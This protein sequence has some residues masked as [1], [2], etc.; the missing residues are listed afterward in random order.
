MCGLILGHSR[1]NPT[2]PG[3]IRPSTMM[4]AISV[5]FATAALYAQDARPAFEAAT[6]KI[7]T[8]GS[9]H[10]R[11]DGSRTQLI[12]SNQTLKRLIER[13]YN[14]KPFQVTGPAWMEDVRLDI[15]AKYPSDLKLDQ[16]MPMLRTLLEDRLKLAV[17]KEA[18]DLPGYAL[19]VAKGG[20][21]LTALPNDGNSS[22]N[23]HGDAGVDT[24][25]A[26]TSMA[27]LA[28]WFTGQLNEAVV[29]ATR[30]SG[31]YEFKFH[32]A[33]DDQALARASGDKEAARFA[34]L[35]EALGTIGLRLHA[36]K[37]PVDVIVVDHVERAPAGN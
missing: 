31:A 3:I 29:D 25:T 34:V 33:V 12:V 5:L 20:L 10:S 1:R 13:A 23:H 16:R 18:K 27:G 8:S 6:I 14:V 30:L 32:W 15:A 26:H 37:V 24:M 2:E 21:K 4:R 9:I 36:Q 28:D 17:H 19:Q 11:T 35:E 7:N 22:I